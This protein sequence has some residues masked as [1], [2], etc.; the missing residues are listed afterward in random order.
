LRYFAVELK[1]L[2]GYEIKRKFMKRVFGPWG[3]AQ[4]PANDYG[5]F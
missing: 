4:I 3:V 2:V 1:A 5:A